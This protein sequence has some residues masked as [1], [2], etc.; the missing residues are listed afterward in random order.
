MC[1]EYGLNNKSEIKSRTNQSE[2]LINQYL[3]I[4]NDAKKNKYKSE[5]LE[6]LKQQ[7]SYRYG[8][9]KTIVYDG[10]RAEVMTGGSK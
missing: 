9:K 4:L 10:L 5:N 1:L 8:S 2:Y 3:E 6:M 7:L